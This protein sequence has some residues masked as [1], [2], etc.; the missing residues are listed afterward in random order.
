MDWEAE[1]KEP[2]AH[3]PQ[4]KNNQYAVLE[5]RRTMKKMTPKVQELIMT[6]KS[7]EC[8]TATKL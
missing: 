3:M 4:L 6:A 5:A 2:A 1:I 7:Q 8:A